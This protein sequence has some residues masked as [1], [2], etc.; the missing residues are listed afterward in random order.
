MTHSNLSVIFGPVFVWR[1]NLSPMEELSNASRVNG[2][3]QQFF[4]LGRDL[5]PEVV[6]LQGVPPLATAANPLPSHALKVQKVPEQRTTVEMPKKK[7]MMGT[8]RNGSGNV[9]KVKP[10]VVPPAEK[11]VAQAGGGGGGKPLKPL[12]PIPRS[13][14]TASQQKLAQLR[15]DEEDDEEEEQSM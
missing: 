1:A 14:M 8:N 11:E 9:P 2:V 7:M 12:P 4:E 10:P 15:D 5:F 6:P 3:V 13:A